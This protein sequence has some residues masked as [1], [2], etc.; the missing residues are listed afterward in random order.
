MM[1]KNTKGFQ[2]LILKYISGIPQHKDKPRKKPLETRHV[3]SLHL[4]TVSVKTEL[5]QKSH[6]QDSS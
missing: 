4:S 2:D 3:P 5:I 6:R 1:R